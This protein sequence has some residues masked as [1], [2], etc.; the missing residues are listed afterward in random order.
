MWNL[1]LVMS[2]LWC[3]AACR[4]WGEPLPLSSNSLFSLVEVVVEEGVEEEVE[5]VIVKVVEVVEMGF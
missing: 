5:V 1:F 4:R 3:S 2:L